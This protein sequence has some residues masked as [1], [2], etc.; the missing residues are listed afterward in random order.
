MKTVDRQMGAYQRRIPNLQAYSVIFNSLHTFILL[1]MTI[2]TVCCFCRANCSDTVQNQ[3]KIALS[4]CNF[5]YNSP[6]SAQE[7]VPNENG[8]GAIPGRWLD[9]YRKHAR[10]RLAYR[11]PFVETVAAL[12]AELGR[13]RRIFGNPTAVAALVL[14]RGRRFGRTAFRAELASARIAACASPT[15]GLGLGLAA[16]GAELASARITALA[17]PTACSRRRGRCRSRSRNRS[18]NGL[19]GHLSLIHI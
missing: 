9:A 4:Q 19:L 6:I 11:V 18:G 1:L 5:R 2:P 3:P 13:I 7:T 12:R 16:L 15:G 8:P 17:S 10:R 14:A